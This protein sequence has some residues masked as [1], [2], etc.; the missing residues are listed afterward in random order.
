MGLTTDELTNLLYN[1]DFN[2]SSVSAFCKTYGVSRNTATKYL[3]DNHIKYNRINGVITM[4]NRDVHGRFVLGAI[5]SQRTKGLALRGTNAEGCMHEE[6]GSSRTTASTLMT[7]NTPPRSEAP[8]KERAPSRA[9]NKIR[10]QPNEMSNDE[11]L[12]QIDS[13]IKS[14]RVR[15]LPKA[16]TR[17]LA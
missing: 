15:S 12:Q 8:F 16:S 17:V 4:P 6:G 1:Y 11:L 14:T 13:G 9:E 7:T 2:K 3:R 10:K 5:K